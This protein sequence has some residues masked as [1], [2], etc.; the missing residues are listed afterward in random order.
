MIKI[1][2]DEFGMK[3]EAHGSHDELLKQ[4][5]FAVLHLHK[6]IYQRL[7]HIE[8]L[9]FLMQMHELTEGDKLIEFL[10][11][12]PDSCTHIQMPIPPKEEEQ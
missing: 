7:G 9:F 6:F 4:A 12:Q 10:E 8:Y 1:E 11:S 3:M 2:Q 5:T